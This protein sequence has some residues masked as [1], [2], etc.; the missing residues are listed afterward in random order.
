MCVC[1]PICPTVALLAL[2]SWSQTEAAGPTLTGWIE[3]LQDAVVHGMKISDVEGREEEGLG[4]SSREKVFPG[5]ISHED[6]TL[7]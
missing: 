3:V 2:Q 5:V 7:S 4:E 1:V 6:D